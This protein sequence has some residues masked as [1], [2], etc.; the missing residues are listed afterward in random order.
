MNIFGI[1]FQVRMNGDTLYGGEGIE[2]ND[3]RVTAGEM[4]V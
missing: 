2:S 1:R 3:L 4:Q